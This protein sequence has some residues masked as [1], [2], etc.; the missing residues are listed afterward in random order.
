MGV[1]YITYA[2]LLPPLALAIFLVSIANLNF[3]FILALRQ[4]MI[5]LIGIISFAVSLSF[6]LIWHNDLH[7]VVRS[8]LGGSIFTLVATGIYV[9]V[10]LRRGVRNAE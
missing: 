9:L 3:M 10:N 4:K 5:M 2:S 6:L 7:A 8:M 1:E